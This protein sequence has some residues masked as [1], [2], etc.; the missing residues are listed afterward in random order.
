VVAASRGFF[1]LVGVSA[2]VVVAF[3]IVASAI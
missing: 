2:L 3:L 1:L